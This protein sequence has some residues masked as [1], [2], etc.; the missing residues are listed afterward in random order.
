MPAFVISPLKSAL[1]GLLIITACAASCKRDTSKTAEKDPASVGE[2]KAQFDI[3]SDSVRVSWAELNNLT[4]H[5]LKATDELLTAMKA[6]S[7]G[8]ANS[9]RLATFSQRAATLRSQRLDQQALSDNQRVNLFDAT[10]DSLFSPLARLAAPGDQAPNEKIRDLVEAM[11]QDDASE[12]GQ[13]IRYDRF[14]KSYNDYLQLHGEKLQKL[15]GKYAALKPLPLF[16][17]QL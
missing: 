10:Q 2:V 15:G 5:K 1:I 8:T 12:I 7:A 6:T 16:T 17:V 4:E 14:V 3:L 9:A 11:R 13:R